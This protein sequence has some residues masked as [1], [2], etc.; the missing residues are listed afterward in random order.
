M[1]K[2]LTRK[3]FKDRYFK[4]NKPKH[5]NSGGIAN[6]QHF[7]EGGLSRREKAIIAAQFA[8][9]LLQATKRPGESSLAGT[10]R[11]VGQGVEKLPATLIA[12]EKAKPKQAARLLTNAELK[13]AKLPPGTSAQI[14]SEGKINVIS[15]PSADALKSAR[16]AKEIKAILGDVAKNYIELDKPVGPLSYRTIAPITNV[17]GTKD[18]RKF[19]E[20]KAD[21]QKTTSFL[22]KAISG[23]AV[24]EQE[25]ERLKRM[26]PQLGDTEVT[27][28]G[29]MK[30]LNKYMDQTIALAED[31]NAEF[32]DAMKIMDNSGATELITFD[33]AK[34]I[35]F[36][37][38][39]DTI[40]LTAGGS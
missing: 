12:L 3:L 17:L 15:K 11:A 16:G 37:R 9:P 39:G 30:A 34:D 5:F 35:K 6:I 14:D 28:E 4:Y 29:K 27:F 7:Q 23:A 18:A 25:A 38:V 21:I 36:R 26:I 1:D 20:L 19:A 22:G 40:D 10:L 33:L 31:T 24:S 32:F 13:A 2:V 8:A